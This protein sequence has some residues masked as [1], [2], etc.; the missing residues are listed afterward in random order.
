MAPAKRCPFRFGPTALYGQVDMGPALF[1]DKLLYLGQYV[2]SG[3]NLFI[4]FATLTNLV[5]S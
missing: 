3:T 2:A 5:G 4:R 1:N